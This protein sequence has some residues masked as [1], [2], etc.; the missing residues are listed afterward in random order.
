VNENEAIVVWGKSFPAAVL[1][2]SDINYLSGIA[3]FDL[4]TVEWVWQEMDRIWDNLG[5]DNRKPLAGQAIGEYYSHPI[6]IVNGIFTSQD[7]ISVLHRDLIATYIGQIG[8]TRIA[9]YGGGFGELALRLRAAASEAQVDIVEP[10]PSKLGMSR[11]GGQ[12]GIR[13]I[14]E[15]DGLYDCVIAQ[16]VLEHVEQPIQL[17][18]Q[19]VCATKMGGY[20][21]FANCFYPV[22]K[23]HL[24]STFYL[25]HMF[26]FVA[27]SMG[28]KFVGHVDGVAHALVFQRVDKVSG[29]RLRIS[30]LIAK[31]IGPLLNKTLPAIR[32]LKR[33]VWVR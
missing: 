10:Y 29:S 5:L 1:R 23:C 13:F 4:P 11:V 15:F 19:L 18:E 9:D 32:W 2:Q 3:K 8:V 20:L 21:V 25:R 17:T 12:D 6:W 31:T 30:L 28:L 16:D 26:V 22:I 14:K 7:A 33:K 24:P 27:S